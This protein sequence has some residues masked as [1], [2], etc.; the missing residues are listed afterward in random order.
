MIECLKASI[1]TINY[2][3]GYDMK[4]SKILA[5]I[6]LIVGFIIL[7]IFI[8]TLSKDGYL[9]INS[10][11]NMAM[12]GQV[13]DFIGG[14]VGT[15]WSLS[16][17]LFIYSTFEQQNLII[18]R[19]YDKLLTELQEIIYLKEV[20]ELATMCFDYSFEDSVKEIEIYFESNTINHKKCLSD[21]R[22]LFVNIKA[23]NKSV[24]SFLENQNR[25]KDEF[26]KQILIEKLS[27]IIKRRSTFNKIQLLRKYLNELELEFKIQ[28]QNNPNQTFFSFKEELLSNNS[29]E[30]IIHLKQFEDILIKLNNYRD[31]YLH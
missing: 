2:K 10:S 18:Q 17:I 3:K 8:C 21:L 9:K 20:S 11:L 24:N 25:I 29:F 22:N 4:A 27:N 5:I 23:L 6:L 15:I 30:S 12:I 19:E 14:V 13:G 31:T 1:F 28:T 26:L 7:I 16:G